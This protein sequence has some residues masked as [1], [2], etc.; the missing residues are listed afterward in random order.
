MKKI[1]KA[2]IAEL[3]AQ[4]LERWGNPYIREAVKYMIDG[5]PMFLYAGERMTKEEID[6]AYLETASKDIREGYNQRA[7]GWYDKWYRYNRKDDGRAYDMGCR[8]ATADPKCA[9]NL[10]IIECMH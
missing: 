5:K 10:N 7:I 6:K 2:Q 3:A 8:L 1:T 4:V 9:E